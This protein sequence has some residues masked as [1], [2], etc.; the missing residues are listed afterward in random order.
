M[1]LDLKRELFTPASDREID[2]ERLIDGRNGV[3][4]ELH[5]DDGADD[6]DDFTG[7]H[8]NGGG[9]KGGG[10]VF[11]ELHGDGG[12]DALDGFTGVHWNG[13]REKGGWR[14]NQAAENCAAAISR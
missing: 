3:F 2:G 10:R 13:G 12:G 9:E 4:G 14:R 1:L 6:L 5:V 8:C 7:V 11:R